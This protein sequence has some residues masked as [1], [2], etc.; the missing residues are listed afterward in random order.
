M[1]GGTSTEALVNGDGM[2]RCLYGLAEFRWCSIF[3]Q[4]INERHC[5]LVVRTKMDGGHEAIGS[6]LHTSGLVS[7]RE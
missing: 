5:L 1:R 2:F 3:E 4:R 7:G 6:L